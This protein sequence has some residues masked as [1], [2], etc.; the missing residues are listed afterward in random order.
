MH[1]LSAIIAAGIAASAYALP[2]LVAR[3]DSSEC[4]TDCTGVIVPKDELVDA[5]VLI[6]TPFHPGYLVG[7]RSV[8]D[9][10]SII[11]C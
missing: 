11:L 9:L 1:L 7:E 2:V 5:E 4:T 3:D 8:N 10:D 6:T